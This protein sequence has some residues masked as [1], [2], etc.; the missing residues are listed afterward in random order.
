MS[1]SRW[2]AY[3][4]VLAGSGVIASAGAQASQPSRQTQTATVA[5]SLRV[6]P[7]AAFEGP[8]DGVSAAVE[9]GQALR[10]PPSA[11]ARVRV[12]TMAATQVVVSG[13]PL[14]GPGG[15]TIRVRF[16][17]SFGGGLSVSAAEPFDCVD[18]VVAGLDGARL[19]SVPLAIGA[20][21]GARET[22]GLPAGLY[23]G[24]V[25]LTATHSAY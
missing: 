11:G 7:Q 8:G 23:A 10:I 19:S 25:T 17:C 3:P 5:V 18:G 13:T 2:L 12:V 22:V 14:V 15:A 21:L 1:L 4:V 16:T 24:R 20:E 9:P 6:L